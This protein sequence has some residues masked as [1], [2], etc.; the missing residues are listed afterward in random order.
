[1]A[2]S[3]L[4]LCTL[5]LT[6]HPRLGSAEMALPSSEVSADRIGREDVLHAASCNLLMFFYL[7]YSR[8]VLDDLPLFSHEGTKQCRHVSTLQHYRWP[9]RS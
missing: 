8:E 2:V 6:I 9:F 1:M 4:P 5:F 3:Y 7:R